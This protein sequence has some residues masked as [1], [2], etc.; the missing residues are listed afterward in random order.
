MVYKAVNA[1]WNSGTFIG[2]TGTLTLFT[3]IAIQG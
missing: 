3:P 2:Q 1:G